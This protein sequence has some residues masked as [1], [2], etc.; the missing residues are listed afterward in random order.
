[1]LQLNFSP[2]PVLFTERLQLRAVIAADAKE[3]FFLRSDKQVLRYLDKQPAKSVEEAV[4]FIERIQKDLQ[5]GDGIL[6][7]IAL[8]DNPAI[9]GSIGFWRMEKEHYRAEIGYGMY[10][11]FQGKGIMTEAMIPVLKFGFEKMKLHSVAA[12][13][14]PGNAASIKLLKKNK[15]VQEGYFKENFF[16]NGQFLDSVILSLINPLK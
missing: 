9:I 5:N 4:E 2:F 12:N 15:F 3:I 11:N 10:P 1:M 6:W 7:G 13:V 14:N 8:K 16:Y